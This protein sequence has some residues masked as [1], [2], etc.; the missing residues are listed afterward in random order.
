MTKVYKIYST[1]L[2]SYLTGG[3][4]QNVFSSMG[5]ARKSVRF[6]PYWYLVSA[7]QKIV[8]KEDKAGLL[9]IEELEDISEEIK[10]TSISDYD[11]LR[12]LSRLRSE[13]QWEIDRYADSLC[14]TKKPSGLKNISTLEIHEF[15]LTNYKVVS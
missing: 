3:R 8:D 6:S 1:V 2:K 13:K 14:N 9:L 15:E 11:V 12:N 4:N 5:E 10:I 7:I